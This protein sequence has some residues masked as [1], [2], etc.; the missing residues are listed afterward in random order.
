MNGRPALIVKFPRLLTSSL[1]RMKERYAFLKHEHYL[2]EQSHISENK[3]RSIILTTDSDFVYRVT[4]TKMKDFRQ[5]QKDFSNGK[6]DDGLDTEFESADELTNDEENDESND[7][8]HIEN[9][10]K[11]N[12]ENF[13]GDSYVD[14]NMNN[15]IFDSELLDEPIPAKM[16]SKHKFLE[17]IRR[18]VK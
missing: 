1:K 2:T 12:L 15:L 10:D 17:P 5:F 8:D 13:N 11:D 3:L 4:N 9:S 18:Q 16:K 6:F 14:E 7:K